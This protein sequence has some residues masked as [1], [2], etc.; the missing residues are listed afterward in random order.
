MATGFGVSRRGRGRPRKSRKT[1]ARGGFGVYAP[2]KR[3]TRKKAK[4]KGKRVRGVSGRFQS[5]KAKK[6][7]GKIPIKILKKRFDR[8]GNIIEKRGGF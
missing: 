8:L 1:G 2:K 5:R 3:K 7:K 4:R 6:Q